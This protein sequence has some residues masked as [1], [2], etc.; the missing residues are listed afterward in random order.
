[1]SDN[2]N[3]NKANE[4][5]ENEKHNDKAFGLTTF[6][7][8]NRNTVFFLLFLIVVMGISS[9]INLPKDSYPEVEQPMVYVG[10]S[11]PG[12][13]PVDIENLI[14]RP[15]E[16]EINDISEI[17][18]IKSTSVQDYSTIIVEFQPDMEIEEALR[19]VKDA[20]DKAKA[21]LPSDLDKDPNVFEMD[22]SEMPIMNINLSGN[23]SLEEL[24][25]IAEDLQDELE[26]IREISSVEIRGV[27]DKEVK[28][29][30][31]PYL[32]EARKVSFEDIENAIRA[33]NI[34]FSGGNIKE[35]DVRRTIRV[36]G[37]FKDP[38]D[39]LDVVVKYENNSIVYLGD[40]ATID[41]G[42]KERQSYARL[43]MKPVVSVDVIKGSGENLLI[44]TEKINK[45]LEQM[46]ERFP[47]G[48]EIAITNDQSQMT[49]DLVNSLENNIISGVILVVL[50]LLFFLGTRNALFVGI[51]IPVSMFISFMILSA[52]GI[53]INMMILFSLILALGMLVD[54]GI[55]IVENVYRLMEQGYDRWEATKLGVGEVAWPIITS[56]ATTLAA[57]LPLAL[58]P[59]LMGEF[60][61]YLPIGVIITLASSLFV[62]LVI[63]P[64]LI[65]AFMRIEN[66]EHVDHRKILRN[67][68]LFVIVGILFIFMGW[69]A[70]GNLSVFFG[71]LILLNVYVLMPASR[72]FQRSFL[73]WLEDIYSRT[74]TFALHGYRPWLFFWGTILLLFLS[75]FL[76]TVRPPKVLFFPENMPKYVNV[77]IEFP[78]GTDIEKT[79]EFSMQIEQ[80]VLQVIEPYNE[81]VE[82][83]IA[84]VGQ[85]TADPND[86]SSFGQTDTPNKARITVNFVEFKDRNGINTTEVM[87]KIRS[88][89]KGYPGVSISVDKDAAG[90]PVG[91]PVSVEVSGE[92]LATLIDLVDRMRN[93][94]NEAGI[95]GIEN[96]QTDLETG[97]PE[98]LVNIDREKARRFGLSTNMI[99]SEIRTSLF[100]KEIS[101][102]KQGEDDYEIQLRL[103]DEYRYDLEALRN[104][105]VTF[106][107]QVTG[108]MIQIPVSAVA[109]VEYSTTFGSVKRK[110]LDRVITL[111]SNVIGGYN[112]TAIN[113][114]IKE[115]LQDFE[116]PVGYSYKF[117]G[118]QEKQAEEMAFLQQ[119][120]ILAIFIIFLIIVA[121]FN[122][123]TTPF[124]IMSSVVLS[125]V[126]VIL[127]LFVFNME[128]VVIMTMIGI[129]SL[130]GVVV[131][132][133]IVLIDF[134]ELI[135]GRKQ[136]Q[137]GV[138]KLDFKHVNEAI[139]EAG[140]TRLRPVLLTAIT[141]ILGLIPLAVGINFDFIK[142]FSSYDSDFYL[143]GD[144]VVFWGPMS[145]TIIF[146]LTFA[147]FLTLVIVPIMYQFFAKINRKLG[148]S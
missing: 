14:T 29:M 100:G 41:F 140:K 144:N 81:I 90:P 16:K 80:K 48:L 118:E 148:V 15:L 95:A 8:K 117:G 99:A 141:T 124:I 65:S 19:K 1:M 4:N 50:V 101:K 129:I 60:M 69:I 34:T 28:I 128:F 86:P 93:Y 138:E 73:P 84:K 137:F 108:K 35:G 72:K 39:M 26:K 20:V 21:E 3:I 68:G 10:T 43:A 106:R 123:I 131:N 126:G 105:Q 42:Y 63:N 83:M 122:K 75:I 40:I 36:V 67:A 55:V 13:S 96:L 33:E 30:A 111:Y 2:N 71:L 62:A 77:F 127:G 64:V 6:S 23:Y 116:M 44:A 88:A 22:F 82:S 147:T 132:N 25:N 61:K 115:L 47:P 136:A 70:F 79:N 142:F 31:N 32:M 58:W 46:K 59:G 133:A 92:D 104:K 49:R 146:G 37:E 134:I 114:D 52:L 109:D 120:L 17:D 113:E 102:F 119:A 18:N 91:K 56:T 38:Q 139:A 7:L 110:D 97:K 94:I 121:Q 125:T 74:L 12:N 112:P 87:E 9:Y 143:G 107:N 57:F 98:L 45:V 5:P 54:N 130:A 76:N 78:I 89:I 11:Y 27:D 135:R 66:K 85:D 53:T 24:E 51:A 103:Q 145:W